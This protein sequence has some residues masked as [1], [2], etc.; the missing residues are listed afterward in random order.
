MKRTYTLFQEYIACV[1]LISF[2]LQ[3]CSG[4][5]NSSMPSQADQTEQIKTN[6]QQII[7]RTDIQTLA[8]QALTAQGGHSVTCYQEAGTLKANVEINAP[9]GFSKS[10]EEV[11]VYIEQGTEIANLSRLDTKQQERHIQFQLGQGKKPARVIIYKDAGLIGGMKSKVEQSENTGVSEKFNTTENTT[12]KKSKA[13]LKRE[14][15]KAN[16][17]RRAMK[18]ASQKAQQEKSKDKGKAKVTD[19]RE[20]IS[21]TK[22]LKRKHQ[23]VKEERNTKEQISTMVK[24]GRKKRAKIQVEVEEKQHQGINEQQSNA[25]PLL[26]PELWQH[27]FSYLDFEGVLAARAVS[28]TWN[29]LITG[30]R[31]VDVVGVNNKPP[32]TIDTRGWIKKDEI[33]INFSG[34][35]ST[36]TTISSFAF[37]HLMGNVDGLPEKFWPYLKASNIHTLGFRDSCVGNKLHIIKELAKILPQTQ[38]HTLDLYRT[39]LEDAGMI[40]LSEVLP[41]TQIHAL[42]LGRNPFSDAGMMALIK[43]LPQTRIHTLDLR[44]LSGVLRHSAAVIALFKVLP[45]TQIH[46]L[47]LEENNLREDVEIIELIKV[48]PQTQIH[49]LNLNFNDLTDVGIVLAKVLPQTQIHTLYLVGNKLSYASIK[50]LAKILPQTRIHS[51]DLNFNDLTDAGIVLAKVLPQTQIHTLYLVE[52]KLSDASIKELTKVLPQ[53]QIH[54][55]NLSGNKL[56]NTSIKELAKVLPQTQVRKLKL[57]HNNTEYVGPSKFLKDIGEAVIELIKVLPQTQIH[58]LNLS[59]NKLSTASIKELGEILPQ[60]QIH[61]L[62]LKNTLIGAKGAKIIA[63][64]LPKNKA[65]TL[66]FDSNDIVNDMQQFNSNDIRNDMQQRLKEQY[67]HIKWEFSW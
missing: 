4:L 50:E 16:Q 18:K 44:E 6:A 48:L 63:Q 55:L 33:R 39:I 23:Q 12:Q 9:Q 20:Y 24:Q 7:P 19:G 21:A 57:E 3:S 26:M 52:S 42:N 65:Y 2:L 41:Q 62:S 14:R 27:I 43:V 45:Q 32:Y 10:Y 66:K 67:P 28:S 53:T 30:F 46:T 25:V 31:Q 35:K 1:L 47:N 8:N 49:T 60:T 15:R 51:L 56:S 22:S 11:N 61:K 40:K 5:G 36:P 13:K 17:K 59:E 37:Y 34:K 38:I 64:C 58:T 54:S 29:H